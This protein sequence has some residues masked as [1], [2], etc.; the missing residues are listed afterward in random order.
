M[1]VKRILFLICKATGAPDWHETL[2]YKLIVSL[3]LSKIALYQIWQQYAEQLQE[4]CSRNLFSYFPSLRIS[5]ACRVVS[6][7]LLL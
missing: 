7:Y 6:F 5:H 3:Y 2:L 1:R 4:D